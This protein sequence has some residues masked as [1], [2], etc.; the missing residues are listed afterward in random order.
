M[1]DTVV[2]KLISASR[3]SPCDSMASCFRMDVVW[4]HFLWTSVDP[5][6]N[7]FIIVTII[8]IVI[9]V[10]SIVII[11]I[12]ILFVFYCLFLPRDAL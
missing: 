8:I 12:F 11:I 4:C 2:S 7:L 5:M 3:G 6:L 1:H 10:I 9:V